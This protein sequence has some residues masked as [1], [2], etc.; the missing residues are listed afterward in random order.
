MSEYN[1]GILY[2]EGK[3]NVVVD[4]L[5]I[6]KGIF[7]LIPLKYDFKEIL[8]GQ[9]V[10]Y[11]WYIKVLLTLQTV[12]KVDLNLKGMIWKQMGYCDIKGECIS[13]RKEILEKLYLRNPRD[14]SIVCIP[15]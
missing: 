11:S 7:S 12:K 3:Q 13:M 10:K 8:L 2:I 15:K 1:F 9:I 4:S 6:K 5:S 14:K